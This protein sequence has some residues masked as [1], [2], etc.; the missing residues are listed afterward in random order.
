M[1]AARR[2]VQHLY[3]VPL[4][5]QPKIFGNFSGGRSEPENVLL[6]SFWSQLTRPQVPDWSATLAVSPPPPDTAW[7][8]QTDF[9]MTYIKNYCA[10]N[11]LNLRIKTSLSRAEWMQRY[12]HMS[13]FCLLTAPVYID[14]RNQTYTV[15]SAPTMTGLVFMHRFRLCLGQCGNWKHFPFRDLKSKK[16]TLAIFVL[17]AHWILGFCKCIY[18]CESYKPDTKT[19][20]LKGQCH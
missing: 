10:K 6:S 18:F 2:R 11:N 7:C 4:H 5:V 14:Y 3:G 1:S 12:E 15:A 17:H 8:D 19:H 9:D 16:P 20:N 13:G